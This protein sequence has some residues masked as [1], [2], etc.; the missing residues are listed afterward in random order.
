MVVTSNGKYDWAKEVKEFDETKAG[1]KGLVDVGVAKIPRFFVHPQESLATPGKTAKNVQLEL[2][3]IDFEGAKTGGARRKEVVEEIRKAAGMWGFFRIVNHC[4]PLH[5][6]DAMLEAVK[7]FH[8][9]PV[10]EKKHLY[11]ADSRQRVGNCT[12]FTTI[13]PVP[14][15]RKAVSAASIPV[16]N[17]LIHMYAPV[18]YQLDNKEL[19][20]WTIIGWFKLSIKAEVNMVQSIS[21][22]SNPAGASCDILKSDET[23]SEV[24]ELY[25]LGTLYYLKRI[26]V[27]RRHDKREEIFMLC[28]REP[29]EHFQRKL[30]S[31][32]IISDHKCYI[33]YYA[34]RDVLKGLH[35]SFENRNLN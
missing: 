32:N 23:A 27:V 10:E 2:P 25:V 35:A 16:W 13:L 14:T 34:M 31:I 26:V 33:H 9:Q 21:S 28:K 17:D 19:V 1:V 7:R 11:T 4:I 29:G 30:F 5:I 24:A 15:S 20:S 3:T 18:F 22:T 8:E 12:T 6:M